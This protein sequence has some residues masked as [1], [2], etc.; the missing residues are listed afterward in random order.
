MVILN[1]YQ[2]YH[3]TNNERIMI[4]LQEKYFKQVIMIIQNEKLF[5]KFYRKIFLINIYMVLQIYDLKVSNVLNIGMFK[6]K[7][8]SKILRFKSEK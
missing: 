7:K 8:L 3:V 1:K 6:K 2:F 4:I 5:L